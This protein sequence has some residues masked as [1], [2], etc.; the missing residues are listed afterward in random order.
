MGFKKITDGT[1]CN[2]LL[3]A[4]SNIDDLFV[5]K[6]RKSAD[7]KNPDFRSH[8]ERGKIPEDLSCERI[9]GYYGVSIEIWNDISAQSLL[10]K[11]KYTASISPKS[12]NNLCVIRFKENNGSVKYTP[13]QQ[14]YNEYHYDFYKD[15][16][17]C[18]ADLEII[19]MI[20][21][22]YI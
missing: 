12:K 4:D 17:F 20:T 13:D 19:E 16:L 11:Y 5:R 22:N 14:L 21:L 9:C 2:C 7:L 6:V 3:D 18:V 15:D 8:I 1:P 10:E